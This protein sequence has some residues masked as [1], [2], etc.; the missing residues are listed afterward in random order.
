MIPLPIISDCQRG[1]LVNH[2][3]FAYGIP[4]LFSGGHSRSSLEGE[5]GDG[6]EEYA[7]FIILLKTHQ[8]EK[9]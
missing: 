4:L 7:C 9:T 6:K 1:C 3:Y 8:K 5:S 2:W